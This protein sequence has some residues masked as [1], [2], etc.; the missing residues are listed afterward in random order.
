MSKAIRLEDMYPVIQEVLEQGGEFSL[1]ATGTSMWPTILGGR[2]QITMVKA[3]TPL[4]QYDL[5]L[6][7]RPSG[8]FVL[9]R[10]LRVEEDGSYTCCG[11]HQ[12]TLERGLR[13]ENMIG[14]VTEFERKGKHHSVEERGY[15]FWV[16]FWAWMLPFRHFLFSIH[17]LYRSCG[18]FFLR[19]VLRIPRRRGAKS[20]G[21][22]E[23]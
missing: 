8:Q 2:D 9:H 3:P 12:W 18:S 21:S 14:L 17:T 16:R 5:P 6:Y 7:R 10:I 22:T 4:K 19:K 1:T 13:Q 11:D 23:S 20:S 15:R